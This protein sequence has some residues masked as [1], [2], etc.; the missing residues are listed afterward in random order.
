M[1]IKKG[2]NVTVITGKDKGKTG[3][4]VRVIPTQNSVVIDGVNVKK[5]HQRARQQGRK[6]QVIDIASPINASNVM[7][8]DPKTN[9]QTR[10]KI[11]TE[12]AKKIRVTV[13]SG[14]EV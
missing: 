4:V 7:I 14:S 8:V 2:D 5:K 6:G 3:K 10:T 9:K 11:K 12:G 1:H 13:K